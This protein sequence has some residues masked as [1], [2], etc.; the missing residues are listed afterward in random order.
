MKIHKHARNNLIFTLK[1]ILFA[2]NVYD[3]GKMPSKTGE[4]LTSAFI[5]IML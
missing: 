1:T 3:E 5:H 4:L 2:L